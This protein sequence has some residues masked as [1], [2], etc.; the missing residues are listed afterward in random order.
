MAKVFKKTAPNIELYEKEFLSTDFAGRTFS[1]VMASAFIHLFRSADTIRVLS[2]I[3]SL[4]DV[5]GVAF[6]STTLHSR[7]REGFALKR[8][9]SSLPIR[10]RKCF[11]KDEMMRALKFCGFETLEYREEFGREEKGKVWMSF[12]VSRG[13]RRV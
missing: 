12:I 4:L 7:S 13:T 2:K 5:Q 3:Y 8:N 1:A 10:Y 11:T 9:F 6:I